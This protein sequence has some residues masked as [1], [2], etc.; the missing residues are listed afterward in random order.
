[1]DDAQEIQLPEWAIE[2][3]KQWQ[4]VLVGKFTGQME[5]CTVNGVSKL[6]MKK[7]DVDGI[8]VIKTKFLD[9]CAFYDATVVCNVEVGG[10]VISKIIAKMIESR[11]GWGDDCKN[12]NELFLQK[13]ST[14]LLDELK[15][16]P[17]FNPEKPNPEEETY[18]FVRKIWQFV[19]GQNLLINKKRGADSPAGV[20]PPPAPPG[21]VAALVQMEGV[22]V[23][24][25]AVHPPA[26][27]PPP[28]AVLPPAVVPPV[29]APAVAPI[30]G[31]GKTPW[32][33]QVPPYQ[34]PA[35]K[36]VQVAPKAPPKKGGSAVPK[37][38]VKKS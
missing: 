25:A 11:G 32:P 24:P 13:T 2:A 23:A 18:L 35:P 28:G 26:L 22:P 38:V 7:V 15:R 31:S 3:D 27:V 34:A 1:M 8:N 20:P 17:A 21:A 33:L 29:G 36:A 10:D 5:F 19:T 9:A 4:R 16:K 14:W 12:V 37:S 6:R 30:L